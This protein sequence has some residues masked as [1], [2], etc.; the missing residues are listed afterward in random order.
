MIMKVVGVLFKTDM[1]SC[2]GQVLINVWRFHLHNDDL[3]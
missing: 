3:R 2:I 1:L